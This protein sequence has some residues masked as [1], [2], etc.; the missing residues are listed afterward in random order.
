MLRG[1]IYFCQCINA[2]T[3][4]LRIYFDFK[5][6]KKKERGMIVGIKH[7]LHIGH[8]F[9]SQIIK[10]YLKNGCSLNDITDYFSVLIDTFSV[11]VWVSVRCAAT[12][13]RRATTRGRFVIPGRDGVRVREMVLV[14]LL[15]SFVSVRE[16]VSLEC[17]F[18][19]CCRRFHIITR[20]IC[21]IC[22]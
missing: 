16:T 3:Y 21:R 20:T 12:R 19:S 4:S 18:S 11:F 9:I 5:K 17:T 10:E 14:P 7:L 2:H 8:L 15:T 6:G 1:P 13:R 22:W